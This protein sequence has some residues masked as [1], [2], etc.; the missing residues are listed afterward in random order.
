MQELLAELNEQQREAV[1]HG[2]GPLLILAGAGSGKTKVLTHRIAYLLAQGVEPRQILAITFT[3]K[4]AEEMRE[5]VRALVG[6]R[7]VAGIWIMTFHAACVRILRQEGR[8]MDLYP[9][10]VIYDKGDQLA[11]IRSILKELDLDEKYYSPQGALATISRAKN[12]LVDPEAFV[13]YLLGRSSYSE[14]YARR[15]LDIYVRYQEKLR[16]NNALDFDDLL[17][18]TVRLF[19]DYPQVLQR[20]RE[21]FRYIMV[22]EYQDTNH[23]QYV[24]IKLLATEEGNLLV[25][26]DDYQ[27]IYGFRGADIRNILDFERDFRQAKIIKLEQN[28]RSTGSVL[29]AANGLMAHNRYQ[30]PKSLWTARGEGDKVKVYR[31]LD[32]RDEAAFVAREISGLK[33]QGYMWRDFSI[34]YRTNAQSRVLEEVFR[35]W[36]IPYKLVGTLGFYERKEIKDLV[37]YLRLLVNPND[38][39]SLR[40]IINIP[41]RGIGPA[42][43]S[44][45]EAYARARQ[46]PLLE[47]LALAEE[48]PGLNKKVQAS[49]VQLAKVLQTLQEMAREMPVSALIPHILDLTGYGEELK[50]EG[51]AKAQERLENL[52]EFITVA[53][54]YEARGEGEGLEDFLTGV[55]LLSDA[56]TYQAGED[57]VVLMTLHSAKGLEFPVVFLV[58][59][60]EG[61]LPHSRSLEREEDVEEERRL[62]YVGIT[63]AQEKLYLV[64]ARE[65]TLYGY[66]QANPLSRFIKEI[67]G[68]VKEELGVG[69]LAQERPTT[70]PWEKPS[71]PP[72]ERAAT[73][74][75]TPGDRVRHRAWGEGTVIQ[76]SGQGE[77]ALVTV[78]FPDRGIKTLSLLYAP[79]VKV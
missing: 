53:G 56:D 77:D 10:F 27:S 16:E 1:Q 55:A 30:K 34:L 41:K 31:A 72:E 18:A 15:L 12:E 57:A 3:N 46:L 21:R 74:P 49:L 11:L 65:R 13:P 62:C 4:T 44:R 60:E 26:G 23:A 38:G 47:V 61:L 35:H 76:I 25:V 22:D 8:H 29:A 40:R 50:L 28:Y 52:R 24:L 32:E 54:E 37:A 5:R 78:A 42:T 51:T 6:E 63:R 59:V 71:A 75:F 43:Y 20:Y 69:G 66:R 79:L 48:I 73:A 33:A 64:C 67:P 17:V 9:G 68:E 45:I 39:I 7:K 14:A 70:G 36:G 19:Q 58:G 2:S